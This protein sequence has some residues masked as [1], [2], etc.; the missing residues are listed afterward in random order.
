METSEP[1]RILCFANNKIFPL[2]TSEDPLTAIKLPEISSEADSV[3]SDTLLPLCPCIYVSPEIILEVPDTIDT[4]PAIEFWDAIALPP[5]KI[6]APLLA[7]LSVDPVDTKIFP[8]P[9]PLLNKAAP[10][11]ST[12]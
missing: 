6:T 3:S 12:T 4:S 8:P 2:A 1:A 5:L 10:I 9:R 7:P 11:N